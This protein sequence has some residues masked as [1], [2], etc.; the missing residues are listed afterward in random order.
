MTEILLFDLVFHGRV[1]L[2]PVSV[3]SLK[4]LLR[5]IEYTT[6]IPNISYIIYLYIRLVVIL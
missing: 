5:M 6:E 2:T 1:L 4:P 3:L